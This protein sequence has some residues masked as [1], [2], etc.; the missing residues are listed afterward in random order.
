M[1]VQVSKRSATISAILALGFALIVFMF[2]HVV[3][4]QNALTDQVMTSIETQ[5][6]R[7]FS[8][9][10]GSF[11]VAPIPFADPT[12]GTGL[13]AV[14]GYLFQSDSG[15]DTSNIGFGYMKSSTGSTG[16]G[17]STKLFMD[18]NRWQFGFTVGSVDLFYDYYLLGTPIPIRQT[19]D[20]LR[21]SGAYG[22]TREFALGVDLRYIRSSI[23]PQFGFSGIIPD[24]ISDVGKLAILN[25]GLTLDWDRRDD[26]I[27]PTSGTNL[28]I[29]ASRGIIV[30]GFSEDYSKSVVTFDAFK[31]VLGNN[32]IATRV[33]ACAVSDAAP[34]YDSCSLGGV[35]NFRGFPVSQFIDKRLLSFQAAWRGQISKR[36]GYSIFAGAGN[37]GGSF[38][39]AMQDDF[40]YATGIG[41]RYRISKKFPVTFS[42][43]GTVNNFG[44]KIVYVYIGQRF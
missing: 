25:A 44:E 7:P 11:I 19:G 8:L 5:P 6:D 1:S 15:S 4:A 10:N 27:Y 31:T 9:R 26:S 41:G 30:E 17:F 32:V 35:D 22:V 16:Y 38:D 23:K 33:A 18:N 2:P 29:D 12:L 24:A 14:V 34:F 42:V 3:T 20:L 40:K 13:V 36:F 37:V 28:A 39:S 43:D 21:L